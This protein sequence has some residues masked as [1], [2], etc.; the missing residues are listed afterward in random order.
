[1]ADLRVDIK[2]TADLSGSQAAQASLQA[3]TEAANQLTAASEQAATAAKAQTDAALALAAAQD[4]AATTAANEAATQEALQEASDRV[5]IAQAKAEQ[6]TK[7]FDFALESEVQAAQAVV[8]TQL[9]LTSVTEAAAKQSANAAAASAAA[10][11]AA[12]AAGDA[13]KNAAKGTSDLG[14]SFSDLVRR[15]SPAHELLDGVLQSSLRSS[16]GVLALTRAV[17]GLFRGFSA[18]GIGLFVTALAGLSGIALLLARNMGAVGESTAETKKKFDEAKRSAEELGR[19]ELN[20]LDASLQK[21]EQQASRDTRAFNE[22]NA[23]KERVANAEQALR[24]AQ[25]QNDPRLS[26]EQ[27]IS[28]ELKIRADFQRAADIRELAAS[29]QKATE[30]KQVADAANSNLL[31]PEAQLKAF[32]AE[33]DRLKGI[34]E[35]RAQLSDDQ[36]KENQ[37]AIAEIAQN[38]PEAAASAQIAGN[39]ISPR[40]RE[41]Q[42]QISELPQATD[43]QIKLSETQADSV[44]KTLEAEREKA[45]LANQTYADATRTLELQRTTQQT[46]KDL[47]TQTNKITAQ[48]EL[49][50][51]RETDRDVKAQN[52]KDRQNPEAD[53]LSATLKDLD[54]TIKSLRDQANNNLKSSRDP[55]NQRL[56]QQADELQGQRDQTQS[57]FDLAIRTPTR[58]DVKKSDRSAAK[59]DTDK[60]LDTKPI[61][62]A[63]TKRS[64]N[65]D[66]SAKSDNDA[67][68]AVGNTI[69]GLPIPPPIDTN[70]L[71][72]G[73]IIYNGK[74]L[75]LQRQTNA[76]FISLSKTVRDLGNQVDALARAQS[77]QN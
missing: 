27:K 17:T 22:L 52:E 44:R 28:S 49:V 47:T 7:D 32:D 77:Q 76:N 53:K 68:K 55:E 3:V 45:R 69:N 29:Q 21:V 26:N 14:N 30:A 46:V 56:N 13:A 16:S 59:K 15:G 18:G 71:K 60:A 20:Q 66:K 38:D 31:A 70:P 48:P 54:D 25:V 51:A 12:S 73:I 6:A 8:E 5:T 24:L 19:T 57:A 2:T 36:K 50:K 4:Q 58:A 34:K 33:T 37:R 1:M 72:E 64:A 63:E 42:R 9:E 23:A 61:E 67:I 43:E 35:L 41:L 11:K 40:A 75:E 39:N 10:A 65:E 62:D 74:I